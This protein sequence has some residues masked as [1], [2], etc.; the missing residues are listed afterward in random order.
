MCFP[1]R[2]CLELIQM[3][4]VSTAQR[5]VNI[6]QVVS[7]HP[8]LSTVPTP[9]GRLQVLILTRAVPGSRA[10]GRLGSHTLSTNIITILVTVKGWV[11]LNTRHGQMSGIVVAKCN[12]TIDW[13]WLW[14]TTQSDIN[15]K[16]NL[17]VLF[18]FIFG[19]TIYTCPASALRVLDIPLGRTLTTAKVV[20]QCLQPPRILL[21]SLSTRAP[22]PMRGR[23]PVRMPPHSSSGSQASSLHK[24][25]TEI[26]SVHRI[27]QRG[28][29][30]ELALHRPTN[31]RYESAATSMW[32]SLVLLMKWVK[33]KE[34]LI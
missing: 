3:A 29:G 9:R 22:R 8:T 24:T 33:W 5:R 27:L 30:L 11:H 19:N 16:K 15:N 12:I 17:L 23:T 6:Q 2:W 32:F 20:M 31:P 4:M 1:C 34:R 21:A 25:T 7:T 10:V 28:Q 14:Y 26:L 18:L 13:L